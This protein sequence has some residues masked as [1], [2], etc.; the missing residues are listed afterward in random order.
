MDKC[1]QNIKHAI[2]I[3]YSFSSIHLKVSFYK[4]YN[5][6]KVV[7]SWYTLSQEKGSQRLILRK[8]SYQIYTNFKLSL[9]SKRNQFCLHVCVCLH[10]SV[11]MHACVCVYTC[12][13]VCRPEVDVGHLG[14]CL[15]FERQ[16]FP[17]P[18]AS[19]SVQRGWPAHPSS[20]F[21]FLCC[22]WVT[23]ACCFYVGAWD[24][25]SGPHIFISN[26]T[27]TEPYLLCP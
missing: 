22:T 4:F 7:V 12:V 11:C 2:F 25:N 15:F 23:E 14:L 18:G 10:V 17:E 20:S 8:V 5:P 19:S 21:V 6:L 13:H 16:S 1:R 26:T 27:P 9:F 3:G 24:L